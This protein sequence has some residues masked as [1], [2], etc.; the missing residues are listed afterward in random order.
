MRRHWIAVVRRSRRP[1]P[2]L[3]SGLLLLV[4]TGAGIA[5]CGGDDDDGGAAP[6]QSAQQATPTTA[7]GSSTAAPTVRPGDAPTI[8]PNRTIAPNTGKTVVRSGGVEPRLSIPASRFSPA[9]E[10]IAIAVRASA[11]DTFPVNAELF[12]ELGPFATTDEGLRAAADWK[13]LEGYT[14]T[15]EPDGLLAGVLLGRYYVLTEQ[16]LFESADGA[17]AAFARYLETHN[18]APGSEEVAAPGVGNESAAWR[19][20]QGK[21]GTSNT[22]AAYHRMVFRR[23]NLLAVVQ[24]YGAAPKMSV[25]EVVAVATIIDQRATGGRAA[26]TPTPRPTVG[27]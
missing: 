5:A 23:G 17:K 3:A 11:P 2:A 21:V 22:D 18:A 25:A 7:Q 10:E 24:T 16:H 8:D 19:I 27:R 14:T 4:L 20:Y 12:A 13:Y 9:Q 6:S 26:A 1:S 15:L